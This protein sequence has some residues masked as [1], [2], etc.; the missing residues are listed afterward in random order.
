M[1]PSRLY[2][3]QAEGHPDDRDAAQASGETSALA[4]FRSNSSGPVAWDRHA[5]R[6]S[7]KPVA[8]PTNQCWWR[9]PWTTSDMAPFF[10]ELSTTF[11]VEW[12]FPVGLALGVGLGLGYFERSR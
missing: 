1:D 8:Q 10:I 3:A 11:A 6:S 5:P 4:Q 7:L 12:V 9:A 2:R